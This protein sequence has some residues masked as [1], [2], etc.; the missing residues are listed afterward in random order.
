MLPVT[1]PVDT[2]GSRT[3]IVRRPRGLGR[4][5]AVTVV[6]RGGVYGMPHNVSEGPRKRDQFQLV[7]PAASHASQ[8]ASPHH[9]P[10]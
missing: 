3:T 10:R 8:S 6:E 2:H 9:G 5:A 4:P 7:T 1:S